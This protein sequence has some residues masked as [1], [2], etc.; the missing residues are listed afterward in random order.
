MKPVADHFKNPALLRHALT[1]RSYCNEHP[2]TE[3]NERLEFL[4]DSVLSVIISDRLFRL[5]PNVPEGE[6]TARRSLLVQTPTL[7]QKAQQL[8]LD[9]QL[10]LSRG[11]EEGGGRQNPS[12]LANTF[13]AVLGG[14]FVD[15]GWAVCTTYLEE[16]F[17]DA[18][19]VSHTQIKDPKS[20]LQEKAQ[21]HLL[22]TPVYRTIS[23]IGPD[24]ARQFTVT[25]LIDNKE[26]G[27]GSGTSKQRAEAEAATAALAKLWQE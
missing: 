20:L 15:Q 5:L 10:L 26:A 4:G 18:E 19:L 22:G 9:K 3:S 6:L 25:A 24:H 12:L 23:I 17:S 14:L 11:E 7:A 27:T 13:E 16:I 2:G 8:G 21:S 1:H